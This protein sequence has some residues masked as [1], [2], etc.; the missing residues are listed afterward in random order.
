MLSFRTWNAIEEN[1]GTYILYV[2]I[3]L[4]PHIQTSPNFVHTAYSH[5]LVL[6]WQ[7]C[8]AWFTS[9]LVDDVIC[10]HNGP[11]GTVMR[12]GF[13]NCVSQCDSPGAA[14]VSHLSVYSYWLTRRQHRPGAESDVYRYLVFFSCCVIC[15]CTVQKSHVN[16]FVKHS[17]SGVTP[18]IFNI[19]EIATNVTSLLS[20]LS[21]CR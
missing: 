15:Q 16:M 2:C 11:Y 12:V 20:I 3:S 5:V 1:S 19:C 7:H 9:G 8:S 14:R 17:I 21:V 6:L 13:V 10:S 4:E 18:R